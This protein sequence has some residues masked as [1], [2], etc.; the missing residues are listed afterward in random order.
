MPLTNTRLKLEAGETTFGT[1]FEVQEF[2]GRGTFAS[3]YK[4]V[5]RNSG[6][7]FAVKRMQ[8]NANDNLADANGIVNEVEIWKTAQHRNIVAL[9][10]TF[11]QGDEFSIVMELVQGTTLF[12]EII[13]QREFCEKQACCVVQQVIQ[14]TITTN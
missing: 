14:N 2:L 7:H 13:N 1:R 3:V 5:E 12:D 11:S 4:C 9:F 8:V 6:R 10:A